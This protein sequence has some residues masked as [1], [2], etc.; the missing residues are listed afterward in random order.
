MW[1]NVLN[2][3]IRFFDVTDNA[4]KVDP[5]AQ[6]AEVSKTRKTTSFEVKLVA[7]L[8][9]FFRLS[10]VRGKVPLETLEGFLVRVATV[11]I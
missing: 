1:K 11:S 5:K 3:W 6:S 7:D 8:P 4:E 9:E 10:E 2:F